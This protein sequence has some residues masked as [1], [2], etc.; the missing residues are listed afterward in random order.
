MK[1]KIVS[2]FGEIFLIKMFAINYCIYAEEWCGDSFFLEV[3]FFVVKF[4]NNFKKVYNLVDTPSEQVGYYLNFMRG[5][6]T[7]FVKFLI[8]RNY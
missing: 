1:K 5:I 4:S 8:R 2:F 3:N 6:F 7:F